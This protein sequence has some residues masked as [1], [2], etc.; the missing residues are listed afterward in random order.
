MYL[1]GYIERM[2]TG[3]RD[4]ICTRAGLPE[5]EFAG[6]VWVPDGHPPGSQQR[7]RESTRG[8]TWGKT[9]EKTR[10]KIL[11][12]IAADPSIST[13][14]LAERIGI[15][16]RGIEWQLRQLKQA[17]R[18]KRVGPRKGGRWEVIGDGDG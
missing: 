11:T 10:E 2:G 4:M 18:L 8:K 14:E 5:P 6:S 13:K 16:P 7:D 3:T 15:T 9:R 17:G 12:L 1:A